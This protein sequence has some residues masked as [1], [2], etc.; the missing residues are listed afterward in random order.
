[1]LAAH[2]AAAIIAAAFLAPA[3][4]ALWS[5]WR[6]G[7]AVRRA[8]ARCLRRPVPVVVP[9]ASVSRLLSA[10]TADLPARTRA[11]PPPVRRGPPAVAALA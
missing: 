11:C 10:V 1:M 4:R 9:V 7:P 8:A 2:V 5:A 6:I 3:E